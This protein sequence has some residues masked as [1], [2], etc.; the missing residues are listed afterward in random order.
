[1]NNETQNEKWLANEPILLLRYANQSDSWLVR[2]MLFCREMTGLALKA[3]RLD[4]EENYSNFEDLFFHARLFKNSF[5]KEKRETKKKLEQKAIERLKYLWLNDYDYF[6][7]LLYGETEYF[8]NRYKDDFDTYS[9]EILFYATSHI[10]DDRFRNKL[11]KCKSDVELKIL[12]LESDY[13]KYEEK[14]K[15]TLKQKK[16]KQAS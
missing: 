3:N 8:Y 11:K 6:I 9:K 4:L 2:K 7:D 13:P 10:L 15:L 5:A 1:M 14:T 12:F 16:N